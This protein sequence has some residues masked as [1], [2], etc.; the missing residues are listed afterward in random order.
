MRARDRT[1]RWDPA[2]LAS[3]PAVTVDTPES[4]GA[5][6]QT[7]P[8]LDAVL[9]AAGVADY[10]RVRIAGSSESVELGSSEVGKDLLLAQTR[11]GTVTLA[12]P[13]LDQSR[14]VR[15]VTDVDVTT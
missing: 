14:W 9:T 2:R 6:R 8:T 7:G 1:E 3:L 4:D 5:T 12:G 13:G 15:D 10:S 11:R